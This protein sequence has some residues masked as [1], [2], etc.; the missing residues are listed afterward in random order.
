VL[1]PTTTRRVRERE[2]V[3]MRE[4]APELEQSQDGDR[5]ILAAEHHGLRDGL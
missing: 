1:K 5:R 4:G 2:G 3:N